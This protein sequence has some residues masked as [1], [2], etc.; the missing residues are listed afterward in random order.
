MGGFR[1]SNWT[2]QFI[3]DILGPP[4]DRPK[5]LETTALGAAWLAGMHLNFYPSMSEFSANWSRDVRFEPRLDKLGRQALYDGWKD[6]VS[7]TLVRS[8][9]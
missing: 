5:N 6:A 2:M 3:S 1:G 9:T 8:S 4:V 7:R